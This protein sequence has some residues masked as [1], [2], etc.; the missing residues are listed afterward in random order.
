MKR[1]KEM[2]GL[3]AKWAPIVT[4]AFGVLTVAWPARAFAAVAGGALPWDAPLTTLQNDLQGPVA[5]AIT[6]AA[7][8][9]TGIMWSVSEHG[10]GVRKMSSLAFGGSCALGATQL[11]TTLFPLGGRFSGRMGRWWEATRG[12][13]DSSIAHPANSSGGSGTTPGDCQLDHRSGADPWRRTPLVHDRHGSFAVDGR[14]L[15]SRPGREI[16]SPAQPGLCPA[17]PL[18]GCCPARY[19]TDRVIA[20]NPAF[21]THTEGDPRVMVER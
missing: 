13:C 6:T 20:P 4:Y 11:M 2:K 10:T 1:F 15:G 7:I 19:C 12:Q 21:R 17:R 18:P 16:R 14:A 3:L 9:G 8:I 5:H